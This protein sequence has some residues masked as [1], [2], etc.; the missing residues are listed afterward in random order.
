MQARRVLAILQC[1]RS[2]A[3]V[4]E[5]AVD[6]VRRSGGF[7]MLVAIVPGQFPSFNTGLFCVPI[8]SLEERQT[9]AAEALTVAVARVPHDVAL[10]TAVD[11]GRAR[12]VAR[13]R[14]EAAAHDLVIVARRRFRLSRIA[15]PVVV[16]RRRVELPDPP[17]SVSGVEFA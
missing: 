13:R 3:A 4:V 7:L 12:A 6:V 2:D 17:P 11:E 8:V 10:L 15:A 14:V 5:Y 1:R 9:A 16:A